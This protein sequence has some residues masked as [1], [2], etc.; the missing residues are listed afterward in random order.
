MGKNEFYE[1]EGKY[2]ITFCDDIW[3]F[4]ELFMK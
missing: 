4:F 2:L 3:R 1:N